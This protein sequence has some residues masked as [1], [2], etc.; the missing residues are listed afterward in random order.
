MFALIVAGGAG[1]G[2]SAVGHKCVG[3]SGA[4]VFVAVGATNLMAHTALL[5]PLSSFAA[6][7]GTRGQR[8]V[9]GV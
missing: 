4:G 2:C 3:D 1:K 5:L 6:G 9:D 7:V 8:D